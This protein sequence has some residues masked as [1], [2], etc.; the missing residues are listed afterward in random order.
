V[1]WN[2]IWRHHGLL[3][4]RPR[5]YQRKK[6]LAHIKATWR[7]FQQISADTKDLNDIP[8]Y[9]PQAQAF[10][11]PAVEYTAREVR[12][13]LLFWA[14]ASAVLRPPVPSLPPASSS[15]SIVAASPGAIWSGRPTTAPSS[16]AATIAAVT[17]PDSPLL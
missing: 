12:S 15:T 4:K 9:W 6:D 2:A 17:P 11:L 10:D 3:K 8:R 14:F 13:G 7:V 1:P 16:S 5:K